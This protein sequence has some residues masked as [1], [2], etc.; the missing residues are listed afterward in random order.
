MSLFNQDELSEILSPLNPIYDGLEKEE[1]QKISRREFLSWLKE[2]S[3]ELSDSISSNSTLDPA[4]SEQR[5][6]QAKI[7]YDF[8]RRTYFPHYYTLDGTSELQEDLE[9]TFLRISTKRELGEKFGYAAPRGFGKS[10][11]S[12]IVFPIW[13]LAYDFKKFITIFS[14]AIELTETLIESIKIELIENDNLK[15]D[16]P[17]ISGATPIWKVGEFVSQNNIKIKGFGS[18]K[19]VR[20]I[21]HGIHR[22]DMVIIDDLENDE[23]VRSR[24]QRDKLEKWLDSAIEFLGS[25]SGE[26]DI[27]Y[28]GTTL[29]RDS[30]LARKLKLAFWNPKIFRA[31][32]RFPTNMHLWDDYTAIY[33]NHGTKKAHDYYLKYRARMDKG[34]KLL[35]DAVSLE[36][37]MIK[38]ASNPRT[39]EAELQNNPNSENQKFDSSKFKVISP[40]QMPKLDKTFLFTDFKGDSLSHKSDYFAHVGGGISKSEQKLYIFHSHRERIKGRKAIIQLVKLQKAKGF[41]LIGGEKNSGFYMGRDWFREKCFEEGIPAHTKFIHNSVNKEDRIGEL[42]YPIADE[43]IIF[44][45][46]HPAL[47]AELDDFPEADFD[48]LSDCLEGLYRLSKLKKKSN[49][50]THYQE[51]GKSKWAY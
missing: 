22:P 11:D 19:R 24:K 35:W 18:G 37:L 14:D 40:T 49:L 15:M 7:D 17:H 41:D 20:G 29:H 43:D 39:F 48:D 9:Q 28:I 3:L 1:I 21:K 32:K 44:V 50:R 30:V 8:F 25:L 4:G 47:F 5:V 42:E 13:L 23:N 38:R 45:G 6:A 34:V 27:L 51:K 10:T 31:I 46:E 12:S 26:L 16:Y 2:F 36:F 33:R